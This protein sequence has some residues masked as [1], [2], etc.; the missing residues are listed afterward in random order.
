MKRFLGL[1]MILA[2]WS[3]LA[4]AAP[5]PTLIRAKHKP[6]PATKHKPHKAVKHKAPKHP[7]A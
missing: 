7:R 2:V 5:Q 6:H 3:G 4:L 1:L